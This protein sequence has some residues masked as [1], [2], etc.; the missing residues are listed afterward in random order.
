MEGYV[1]GGQGSSGVTQILE[2]ES[3]MSLE[4]FHHNMTGPDLMS[5]MQNNYINDL[6]IYKEL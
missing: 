4:T 2:K 3:I 1:A 6:H 5:F